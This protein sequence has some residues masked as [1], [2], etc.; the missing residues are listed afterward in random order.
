MDETYNDNA[1]ERVKALLNI[2]T[3]NLVR[4]DSQAK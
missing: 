3:L 4:K 1:A 2:N